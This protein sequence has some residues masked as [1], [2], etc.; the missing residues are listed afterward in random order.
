MLAFLQSCLALTAEC[1]G[2]CSSE[3]STLMAPTRTV[4]VCGATGTQGGGVVDVRVPCLGRCLPIRGQQQ[5]NEPG[6]CLQALLHA[7]GFQVRG[8][9]RNKA[10]PAAQKLQAAGAEVV[11]GDLS[12]PSSLKEA[13]KGA[14]YLSLSPTE[15]WWTQRRNCSRARMLLTL[16]SRQGLAPVPSL[17]SVAPCRGGV[18]GAEVIAGRS[19]ANL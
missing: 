15:E 12:D 6:P 7:D 3:S 16:Q 17:Q 2:L 13:F 19:A 11:Q 18:K 9:T 10:S 5:C 8:L 4:V 1:C 14:N